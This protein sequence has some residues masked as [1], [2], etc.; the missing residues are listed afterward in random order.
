MADFNTL[1]KLVHS[2]NPNQDQCPVHVNI[3][4]LAGVMDL[5]N[6]N[7]SIKDAWNELFQ[8]RDQIE[9]TRNDVRLNANNPEQFVLSVLLWGFPT[10][11]HGY[12]RYVLESWNKI[13]PFAISILHQPHI[14]SE[15]FR[16]QCVKI[17]CQCNMVALAFFSKLMY[18]SNATIDNCKCAIIDSFVYRGITCIADNRLN[19]VRESVSHYR[20]KYE[21]YA[22]YV[23]RLSELNED[24]QLRVEIDCLEYAFFL[25]GRR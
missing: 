4:S 21:S 15:T 23:I 19:R 12:V 1:V 20:I 5:V 14:T 16:H 6:N 18:F 10:N 22:D 17:I 25:I 8:G 11:Q 9:L 7:E 3:R 24:A 13:V 2:F